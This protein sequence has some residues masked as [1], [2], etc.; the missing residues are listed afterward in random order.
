[1]HWG[2]NED[3]G[4]IHV[5]LLGSD[6]SLRRYTCLPSL[7]LRHSTSRLVSHACIKRTIR[8]YVSRIPI[9][10]PLCGNLS[11]VCRPHTS[12][13]IRHLY[14]YKQSTS[15]SWQE[16]NGYRKSLSVHLYNFFLLIVMLSGLG[17]VGHGGVGSFTWDGLVVLLGW[18][19][20]L[21]VGGEGVCV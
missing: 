8:I 13:F 9:H 11:P 19:S 20:I 1:V 18:N 21:L 16:G 14:L 5:K 17:S 6:P 15:E 10:S 4:S 12:L 3:I 7:T 2:S